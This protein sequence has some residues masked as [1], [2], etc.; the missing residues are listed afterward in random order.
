MLLAVPFWQPM[1]VHLCNYQQHHLL[2]VV[3]Q[4]PSHT[5][6]HQENMVLVSSDTCPE[7][8][9]SHKH[10]HTVECQINH[11]PGTDVMVC[12]TWTWPDDTN[13]TTHALVD[14][15]PHWFASCSAT[16]AAVTMQCN[17]PY[18]ISQHTHNQHNT[19]HHLNV[20]TTHE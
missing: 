19:K 14:C 5:L 7:A 17:V 2:C 15:C 20:S 12:I 18:P 16:R 13:P 3:L 11:I 10:H 6:R 1:A 8:R 9:P 4:N